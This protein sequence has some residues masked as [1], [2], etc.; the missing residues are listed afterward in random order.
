[1][2]CC[3]FLPPMLNVLLLLLLLTLGVLPH[4]DNK[5]HCAAP[6]AHWRVHWRAAARSE[7]TTHAAKRQARQA[8][9]KQQVRSNAQIAGAVEH[10]CKKQQASRVH[11]G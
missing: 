11:R 5:H 2:L 6:I 4:M 10:V 8:A 9:R 3:L 1:M 7:E